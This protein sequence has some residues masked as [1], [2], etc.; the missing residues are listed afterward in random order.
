MLGFGSSSVSCLEVGFVDGLGEP[1]GSPSGNRQTGPRKAI[2]PS[3]KEV[4]L[5]GETHD[6][7]EATVS[8]PSLYGE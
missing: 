1:T 3:P 2:H 5:V 6:S 4:S 8:P 7:L